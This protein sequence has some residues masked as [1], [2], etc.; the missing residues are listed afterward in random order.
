MNTIEKIITEIKE[1]FLKN[2]YKLAVAESLTCGYIQT[3][4]GQTSGVSGFFVGGIITYSLA[5]KCNLLQVDREYAKSVNCVSELVA[6]Q[7]AIGACRLF[8]VNVSIATTGYAE[9]A[10]DEKIPFAYVAVKV[11]NSIFSKRVIAPNMNRIEVQQYISM[12]ALSYLLECL[13]M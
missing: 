13:N 9:P 3:M 6:K 5:T 4:I 12:T 10:M 7:M 1:T 11:N 8:E 2:N